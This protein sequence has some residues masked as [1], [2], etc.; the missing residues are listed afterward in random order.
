MLTREQILT[1]NNVAIVGSGPKTLM[2]AHGFGCDQNMWQYLAPGL[3]ERYTLVLFDYVG[4]GKSQISAFSESRYA[5]LEGY[6]RDVYEICRA[7]G[8]Q[9]VHFI[10][11][12][13][14]CTIGM[15]AALEDPGRF[16]S[17]VMICPS[18]CFLNMPPDYNGGFEQSDLEELI[19]LM[20][21]N[22]M[23]WASY[24]APLAMGN[25]SSEMLIGELS[26]SFCSTD[27]V[28]AKTFARATFFS[29]Y[30]HLL[31][32]IQHPTLILQ[33]QVDSLA[34]EDVG[35]Y[36]HSHMPESTLHV[37]PSE[38]HCIH[39]THPDLVRDEII[40]WLREQ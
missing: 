37:L 12:S 40:R 1:R 23:G 34:N 17:Q 31:P 18:P 39:M 16:A 2:L 28:V 14:S 10:G 24:L 11:H 4:S 25:Q 22:Y 19:D 15:I 9:Q 38:G 8:L 3:R 21:R 35:K 6:A 36:M 30:R 5:R 13:V 26:D 27:P 20:D 32:R 7:L 29:D 33:S